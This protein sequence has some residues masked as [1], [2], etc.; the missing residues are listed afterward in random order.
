M[1]PDA[2]GIATRVSFGN[3]IDLVSSLG[4]T[5]E[6]GVLQAGHHLVGQGGCLMRMGSRR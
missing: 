4:D 3:W 5:Y 1:L 6:A 2:A